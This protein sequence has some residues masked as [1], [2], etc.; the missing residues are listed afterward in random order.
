M[1]MTIRSTIKAAVAGAVISLT[2]AQVAS[3]ADFATADRLFSQ[4]EN[5]KAVIAQARSEYLQLLDSASNTNDKIRA[6]EQLGRLALYEGEML[7]AKTDSATRRAVFGDCWC[8]STSLFTRTCNEPGWVEKISPAAI[9][10]RISAYYYYRGMC[11]GYWGEASNVLEQAA[12]SGALRDAVNGGIEIATQS[13]ESSAYEGGAVHRVAANVWSNPLA[14][15]V[16]LYDIKKALVQIDRALAAPANG[17]QDPGSLFF[18]NHRSKII[19]MKQLNSDEPSAGWKDK[20]I[21]FAN[22]TLLDMTDRIEQDQIPTSRV[23]EFK[24]IYDHLKIDYRALAGRE[25]QPE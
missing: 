1:T 10:Q 4:R 17:S 11:I 16:G 23:P 5:N 2:L 13:A 25:W 12:F 24:V 21:D 8:R 22:E 6:A 20:A 3:A 14:R 18:D 15:A 7:A 9:G 19:V